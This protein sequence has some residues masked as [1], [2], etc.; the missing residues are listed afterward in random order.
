MQR[1]V[2][3][4]NAKIPCRHE[5]Q[6]EFLSDRAV[7]SA[8]PGKSSGGLALEFTLADIADIGADHEAKQMFGIDALRVRAGRKQRGE[9]QERRPNRLRTN[10]HSQGQGVNGK[11]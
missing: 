7:A 1:C 9:T 4:L 5:F 8:I 2:P 11:K 10:W 3:S 6:F